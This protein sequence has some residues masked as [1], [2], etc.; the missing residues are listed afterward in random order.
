MRKKS[1][2]EL[3]YIIKDAG[4]AAVCM[5]DVNP[6][7]EAKYLDQVNDAVTELARRRNPVVRTR[8]PAQPQRSYAW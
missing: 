7:A 6:V 1:I 4:E 2:A 3:E 8:K 5:K